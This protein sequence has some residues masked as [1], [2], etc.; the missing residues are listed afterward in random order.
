MIRAAILALE[1]TKPA[2]LNWIEY[3]AAVCGLLI[4]LGIILGGFVKIYNKGLQKKINDG[5]DTALKAQTKTLVDA[6]VEATK[7]IHPDANGGSSLPDLV[8]QIAK[9]DIKLDDVLADVSDIRHE[10][11][12]N[13]KE[14]SL[15]MDDAEAQ[16]SV[17]LS[18]T[19]E[20]KP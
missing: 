19:E 1:D 16:R 14:M 20:E 15:R 12:K 4:S 8:K 9:L 11:R 10:T 17:I 13:Y 3:A 18:N 5:V 6:L 7:P 2:G